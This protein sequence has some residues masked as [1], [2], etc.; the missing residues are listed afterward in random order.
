MLQETTRPFTDEEREQLAS[1]IH[2]ARPLPFWGL[3]RS[4]LIAVITT[5]AAMIVMPDDFL[6]WPAP[7]AI[8]TLAGAIAF[9]TLRLR[10]QEPWHVRP[11][12]DDLEAGVAVV[13]SV[14]AHEAIAVEEIEDEGNQYLIGVPDGRGIFLAGQDLYDCET[15]GRFPR[16]EFEVVFAPRSGMRLS[17]ST[18]GEFLTPKRRAGFRPEEFDEADPPNDGEILSPDRYRELSEG[19]ANTDA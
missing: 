5:L 11:Y 6:P 2:A 16:E 18:R 3:G 9:M 7:F 8:G 13:R 17:L 4:L 14:R 12:R 10:W 15:E 1:L 19:A